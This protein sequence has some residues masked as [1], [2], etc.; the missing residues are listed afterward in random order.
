[1]EKTVTKEEVERVLEQYL[2]PITKEWILNELFPTEFKVGDWVVCPVKPSDPSKYG[3]DSDMDDLIG[4]ALEVSSFKHGA[5]VAAGWIWSTKWVRHATHEEIAAAEWEEGRECVV[6]DGSLK[7]VRV[8]SSR[9]GYF[10]ES[11]MY[12]GN[13]VKF[14]KYD[15]IV[16]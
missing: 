7:L 2:T 11:G 4:E 9:V 10:Y 13:E 8:S 6:W 3:W 16:K 12:S 14:S 15:F 5:L 1:M